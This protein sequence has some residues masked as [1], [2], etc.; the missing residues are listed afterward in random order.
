MIFYVGSYTQEGA[1][2]SNPTGIGISCCNIDDNTGEIT[3]FQVV[4]QRNPSYLVVSLNKQFLYAIEEM[5]QNLAPKIY[6]YRILKSGILTLINSQELIG[7]YACHL[8]IIT[9]HLIVANYVSGNIL[10]FPIRKDGGLEPFHQ[11]IQHTGISLNAERQEQAHAHMV[12]QYEEKK[13]FVVDLGIDKVK[14]YAFD[15]SLNSWNPQEEKDVL[16]PGGS[17]PRHMLLDKTEKIAYVLSELSGEV[18]VFK[19]YADRFEQVQRISFV[20]ESYTGNFGGAAIRMHPNGRFLY[21][22]CRGAN[23]ITVFRISDLEGILVY[24]ESVSSEGK[25]PRDFNISPSGKWLIAANQDTDTL[26]VFKLNEEDGK[27]KKHLSFAMQTPVN[28]CWK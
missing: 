8:A 23:V 14:V 18:F 15:D 25:S 9:N 10:S 16:L 20:P 5:Y 1:P 6:A 22:S 4:D 13:M 19:E 21:A 12:L 26:V 27:I 24:V 17:G 28:I 3:H 7:D 11:V 2:A